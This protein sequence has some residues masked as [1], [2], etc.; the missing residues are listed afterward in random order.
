MAFAIGCAVLAAG[1]SRRL[2]RPK[3]LV[4]VDGVPLIRHVAIAAVRSRCARV[5]IVLG[6]NAAE[7]APTLE[8]L[9]VE[10]VDNPDWAEGMAASVRAAAAWAGRH[11]LDALLLAVADQPRLSSL[12]LDALIA[13]SNDGERAA[14]SAYGGQ[15]GVPAL[16]P[17]SW[18][19]RL[20]LLRGDAGA[21]HL[22]RAS[23]ELVAPVAWQAGALDVDRPED[24]SAIRVGDA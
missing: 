5:A 8:G 1:A 2:G 13:A 22:L 9:D 7:V 24:L 6:A 15:L 17:R 21:R 14:A 23:E 20:A 10:C 18:N 16:F 19:P 12:H 3:Q 4:L 11:A